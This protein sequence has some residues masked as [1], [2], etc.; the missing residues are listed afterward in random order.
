[1]NINVA[2]E[3]LGFDAAF[4]SA[5][6]G[7][8]RGGCQPARVITVQREL[9]TLHTGDREVLGAVSGVFAHNAAHRSEFPVV[10]DFVSVHIGEGQERAVIQHVLPRRSQL[11]R[12][13]AGVTTEEQVLT[14]NVDTVFLVQSLN[15]DFNVR[16]LERY[17]IVAWE[18]GATPVIVLTKS[19]LC[20]AAEARAAEARTAGMG[21]TVHAVSALTGSG[22]GT[23]RAY[24]SSGK[25]AV[26]LG[27]SG[28]GKSTL[29]NALYGESVQKTFAVRSGDDRGKH[30]TTARQLIFLPDGGMIID[31]PGMR[32]LQLWDGADGMSQ[33]FADVEDWARRC[34]FRDCGHDNES[35]C[36]V[37]AALA[38]GD[39]DPERFANFRK[40]QREL[41][42]L[43]RKEDRHAQ[44]AEQKKW[45]RATED[46]R[47]RRL[48][49]GRR[50]G[51]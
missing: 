3:R 47:E 2:M 44:I 49:K 24:L 27:S 45:K 22:L 39:L 31:T 17:L 20:A 25:T 28:A 40:L 43:A 9:Y 34:R 30:T 19:D 41:A 7:L 50:E 46:G 48:R 29:V 6:S 26:A 12:H 5:F 18:S 15:R 36:A 11:S 16:R 42:Y 4:A 8:N 38:D 21:A 51:P 32:E 33:A 37:Q 23:L 14:A 35:G 13:I 1:M 10:G